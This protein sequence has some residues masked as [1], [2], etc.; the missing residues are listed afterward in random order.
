MFPLCEK[1]CSSKY[2]FLKIN[3]I[4]VTSWPNPLKTHLVESNCI[5][6][7]FYFSQRRMIRICHSEFFSMQRHFRGVKKSFFKHF[8]FGVIIRYRQ[9]WP[10][11]FFELNFFFDLVIFKFFVPYRG[12]LSENFR[13]NWDCCL[14]KVNKLQRAF[15]CTL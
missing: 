12:R 7:Q 8:V 4:I 2:L 1:I 3:K 5:L 9:F 6:R 14:R 15:F 11:F 10:Y 13:E